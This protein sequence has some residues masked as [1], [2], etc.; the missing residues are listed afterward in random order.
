MFSCVSDNR[1]GRSRLHRDQ[2]AAPHGVLPFGSPFEATGVQL[3]G[4]AMHLKYQARSRNRRKHDEKNME[5]IARLWKK[6]VGR[7]DLHK[8]VV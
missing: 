6:W 8:I 7:Y 4:E 2:F 1:T 3:A 5:N